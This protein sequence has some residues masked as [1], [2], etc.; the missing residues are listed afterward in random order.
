MSSS[1]A[2]GIQVM[3]SSQLQAHATK[4]LLILSA[5]SQRLGTNLRL[6]SPWLKHRSS[7]QL[8][9]PFQCNVKYLWFKEK[10]HKVAKQERPFG[11]TLDQFWLYNLLV[12]L[13]AM[14]PSRSCT[15]LYMYY[16]YKRLLMKPD[17]IEVFHMVYQSRSRMDP[18]RTPYKLVFNILNY[19]ILQVQLGFTSNSLSQSLGITLINAAAAVLAAQE[20]WGWA[21]SGQLKHYCQFGIVETIAPCRYHTIC[22]YIYIYKEIHYIYIYIQYYV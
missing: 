7:A 1:S 21:T 15:S 8:M 2:L 4:A 17:V 5:P 16:L 18:S 14:R 19:K 6:T 22:V 13:S 12:P 9:L 3:K 20:T 10:S 11:N